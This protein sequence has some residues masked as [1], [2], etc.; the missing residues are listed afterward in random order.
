MGTNS[1]TPGSAP[2]QH[3]KELVHYLRKTVNFDDA[4]ISDGIPFANMLPENA[5][6]LRTT[7]NILTAFN[8]GTTN[9]LTVGTDASRLNIVAAA[10]VNE[11]ATGVTSVA[12]G[13]ALDLSGGAAMPYVKYAQT[14]TAATAGKACIVIEYVPD[15]DQ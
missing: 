13:A 7:V 4:G 6:I 11:A 2:R 1:V 15:N 3:P 14:G 8:A 9:V 12:T 10:D 5:Q